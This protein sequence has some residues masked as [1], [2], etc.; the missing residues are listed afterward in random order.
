M[1]KKCKKHVFSH[2]NFYKKLKNCP[3][4]SKIKKL[5]IQKIY[6]KRM[7]NKPFLSFFEFLKKFFTSFPVQKS[8]F[9]KKC[10]K[11]KMAYFP[12]LLVF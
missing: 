3:K 12:I 7:R 9:V 11:S 5:K 6:K 10:K 8:C 1:L 4:I 2:A